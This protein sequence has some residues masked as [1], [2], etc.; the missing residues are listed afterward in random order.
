MRVGS[1]DWTAGLLAGLDSGFTIRKPEEL[2]ASVRALAR[3]LEAQ[4]DAE[5][6][7]AAP[8]GP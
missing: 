4:A 6:H 5:M 1:L 7:P 8:P 2:R 3:R